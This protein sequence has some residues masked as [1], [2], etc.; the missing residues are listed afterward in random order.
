MG[1]VELNQEEGS[2]L[3]IRIRFLGQAGFIFLMPNGKR[4][5]IDAY[6]SDAAERLFGFKR[7]IPAVV[8]PKEIQAHLWLSTHEHIDHLDVDS[9]PSVYQHG[10]TK[11]IGAPDC[12]KYYQELNF[13]ESRFEILD[14]GQQWVDKDLSIRAVFA[15]HGELAPD[16]IG[17]LIEFSGIR[18]YH[19]GDTAF[20]PEQ[21]LASLDS[22][23]DIMIAP[24]NGT[25]GNMNAIEACQLAQLVKPTY[26]IPAHYW[27]FVEHVTAG[28][29][30]D[31][32]TF[33]QEAE[34]L[35]SHTQPVVMAAG[36]TKQFNFTRP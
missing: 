15:D 17:F 28:G 33:L 2:P 14:E 31:P 6:L 20:R 10:D 11:F 3:T 18:I 32:S 25:Y 9:L 8:A 19:A 5:I 1:T 24:I 12:R 13:H 26:L 22:P 27:M 29:A 23:V 21:I 36:E 16:A 30:G 7:M 4:I 35:L 34:L